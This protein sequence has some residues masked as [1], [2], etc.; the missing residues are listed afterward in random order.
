MGEI[1]EV[2]R[3]VGLGAVT[4]ILSFIKIGS[5]IQDLIGWGGGGVGCTYSHT[6]R[7]VITKAYFYVFKIRKVG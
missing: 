3:E 5:G 2:R 4:Y 1:Y 6:Y 7:K